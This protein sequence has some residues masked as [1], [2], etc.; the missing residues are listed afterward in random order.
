GGLREDQ[1]FVCLVVRHRGIGWEASSSR[2]PGLAPIDRGNGIEHATCPRAHGAL[3][4]LT[5]KRCE[6]DVA[7]D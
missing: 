2:C 6:L 3:R 4:R 5:W 7:G 1:G